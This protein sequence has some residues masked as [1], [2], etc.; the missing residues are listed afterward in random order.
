MPGTLRLVVSTSL[1]SVRL[2]SVRGAS[3][4]CPRLRL[5]LLGSVRGASLLARRCAPCSWLSP[6]G[7]S[8][9]EVGVFL[10]V[11]ILK[12]NFYGV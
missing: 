5:G 2:G 10:G 11:I 7:G 4:L 3:L 8:R 6:G 1:R 9:L 12:L